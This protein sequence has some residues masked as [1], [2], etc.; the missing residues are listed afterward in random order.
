MPLQD[1][2]SVVNIFKPNYIENS[3]Q[4]SRKQR[5]IISIGNIWNSSFGNVARFIIH[6]GPTNLK[7]D[8]KKDT[9]T[10]GAQLHVE[11]IGGRSRRWRATAEPRR[12]VY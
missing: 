11:Y 10:K 8:I 9:G 6:M 4:I 3:N 2:I 12:Y 5:L 1:A 7:L